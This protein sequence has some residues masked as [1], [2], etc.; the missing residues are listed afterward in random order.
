MR[1]SKSKKG[2][3]KPVR[4]HP[5]T[6]NVCHSFSISLTIVAIGDCATLTFFEVEGLSE[7][8]STVDDHLV[9]SHPCRHY[10]KLQG[11]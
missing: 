7:K 5:L 4:I 10:R 1:G 8:R 2:I 9:R 6:I 3:I 11:G